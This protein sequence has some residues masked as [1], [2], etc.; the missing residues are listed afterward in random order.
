MKEH[1]IPFSGPMARAILEGRKTVTR[2][3]VKPQPPDGVGRIYVGRYEP[4]IVD[5]HG[6]LQ[7]GP[8]IFGAYDEDGEW[9]ARC[10]YGEP[11]DRLWVREKIL[12]LGEPEGRERW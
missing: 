11:G 8:G 7:P 3:V 4:A 1:P 5:R 6:E 10:P 12:R 9:G 2:R